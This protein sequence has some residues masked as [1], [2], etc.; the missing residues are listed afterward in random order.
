MGRKLGAALHHP[1]AISFCSPI[2]PGHFNKGALTI[3]GVN[4]ADTIFVNEKGKR[5]CDE[6]C[7]R[8]WALSGNI[9]AQQKHIF[10]VIDQDFVEKI[11]D[12]G[13]CHQ[14]H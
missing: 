14:T 8:D 10:V 7:I 12:R 3:C 2:L 9:G 13:P 11:Q 5:F 1:E 6:S 4:Q